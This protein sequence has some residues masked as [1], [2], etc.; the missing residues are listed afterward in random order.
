MELKIKRTHSTR[1]YTEGLLYVNDMRTT[2]TIEDTLSMLAPGIYN[3]RLTGGV[4]RRRVIAIIPSNKEGD[5]VQ[6]THHFE[7]CGSHISSRKNNSICIGQTI[8]PGA[9]AKGRDIYDR[10]FDRIEKAEARKEP[11]N[12]V[13]TDDNMTTGDPIQ[14]WLA[15]SDHN[16]PATKR[17][18]E[19][20]EED[21][22]VDIY[23]GNIHI[24]HLTVE[25]QKALREA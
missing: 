8:I 23:E 25:E 24:R 7:A 6:R 16:C 10:L 21:N 19:L 18:V 20:N 4:K 12:L 2:S 17:R 15:P 22:S 3:V 9:L 14:Y 1:L 13:I 11:I 5:Y